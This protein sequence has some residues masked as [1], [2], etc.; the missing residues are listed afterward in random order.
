MDVHFLACLSIQDQA[1]V[2]D[3]DVII[4]ETRGLLFSTFKYL[5]KAPPSQT[6]YA[7]QNG[8]YTIQKV[9]KI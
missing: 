6:A 8:Q 4:G 9:S 7:D 2:N 3:I 1:A 5:L